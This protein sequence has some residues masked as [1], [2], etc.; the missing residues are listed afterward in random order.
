MLLE[1]FA[2][3]S[4]PCSQRS[5]RLEPVAEAEISD[6]KATRVNCS[7]RVIYTEQPKVVRP[8]L[9]IPFLH[10]LIRLT[11]TFRS[12]KEPTTAREN[13]NPPDVAALLM[14]WLYGY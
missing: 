4:L 7:L 6:K 1:P 2:F 10:A 3:G 5:E 9:L 13:A 8:A 12:Y 14:S 11:L